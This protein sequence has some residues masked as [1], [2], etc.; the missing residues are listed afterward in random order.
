M[1]SMM[2]YAKPTLRVNPGHIVLLIQIT[3]QREK[4]L[5]KL[6]GKLRN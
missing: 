3:Y 6:P 4:S 5:I 1:R 2:G